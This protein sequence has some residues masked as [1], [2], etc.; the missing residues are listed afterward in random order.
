MVLGINRHLKDTLNVNWF[1]EDSLVM[2]TLNA[3]MKQ[4]QSVGLGET[5]SHPVML[6][7]DERRWLSQWDASDAEGLRAL[8]WY[9]IS[10]YCALRGQQARTL[11]VSQ[12]WTQMARFI[13]LLPFS[14]KRI[15][16]EG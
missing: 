11:R 15:S 12:S 5:V 6:N 2:K 10:K 8:V 14:M 3:I 1:H 9:Y 7:D 4:L 16:K 13:S